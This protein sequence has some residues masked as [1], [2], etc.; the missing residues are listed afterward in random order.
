MFLFD[1]LRT[2][3]KSEKDLILKR[4]ALEENI[5]RG[6]LLA[7][8]IIGFETLFMIID[9][10]GSLL[11][12]R[13]DF[14]FSTYAL[15]YLLMIFINIRFVI[16]ARRSPE[17]ESMSVRQLGKYETEI[18]MYVTAV[19]CWGSILSLLDQAL[20]GQLMV[21][22]VNMI[23]CSAFFYL[24]KNVLAVPFVLSTLILFAGLPFFQ[25]SPDVLVGHYINGGV[26]IIVSWSV[27]RIMYG[28]FLSDHNSRDMIKRANLMLER[29]IHENTII[30]ARLSERN[31]HLKQLS[32]Y[33]ELTGI[34]NRR[35]FRNFVDI[36]LD[37]YAET[38]GRFSV[39][40]IDV[41]HFKKFNDAY[42]HGKGD[43]V[44]TDIA[45]RI[46]SFVDHSKAFAA[47]WGGEEFIYASFDADQEELAAIADR[48]RKGVLEMR[49]P[50]SGSPAHN[51]ITV[52]LGAA[53]AV[54]DGQEA[55][56]KCI[57]MADKALY[58]AKANGR[59]ALF[60]HGGENV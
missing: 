13:D 30:N 7:Y 22:M 27:S 38:N 40:M 44:L 35:A 60:V 41:D 10:A 9:V 16:M 4:H 21:F 2:D 45:G 8:L 55:I 51:I 1:W 25:Q 58:R 50:H 46:N 15:M 56:A 28:N 48:I 37:S 47:R 52:S 12:M 57:E 31:M 6:V 32:L 11:K 3:V 39:I 17:V 34:P 49:I 33:D 26:F 29:E 18:A 54:L 14:H 59:N 53:T 19:M 42:G 43:E 20:Y 36:A 5:K 23:A 24:K